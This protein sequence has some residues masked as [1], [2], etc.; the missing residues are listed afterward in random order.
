[1]PRWTYDL[2]G[3][4]PVEFKTVARTRGVRLRIRDQRI[5]VNLPPGLKPEQTFAWLN[6]QRAWMIEQLERERELRHSR[7]LAG[8]LIAPVADRAAARQLL[9]KRLAE[10]A[11]RHGLSYNRLTVRNQ[12]S[13]WGSCSSSG[14]INLNCRLVNLPD[15]LRDYV[16]LHELAHTR[17]HGHGP[18]FWA[19]LARLAP[20]ARTLDRRLRQY[21]L[22]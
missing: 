9:N 13:R 21:Q 7:Q 22:T 2:S 16:I 12:K 10:L 19:E 6:Q 20:E 11:H 8:L 14:N 17:V 5:C 15:E 3:I 4:G 18:A 1:M